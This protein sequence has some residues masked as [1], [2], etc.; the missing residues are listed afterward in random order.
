MNEIEQKF[1]D[2]YK[3][4]ADEIHFYLLP[5][6]VIGIYTVDF[7]MGDCVA[8]IDGH[9]Y[10]KTK[11]QRYADY[12]RERFLQKLGYTVVRFMGTE[13]FLDPMKCVNELYEIA[14]L[15]EDKEV[16]SFFKGVEVGKNEK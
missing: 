3:Q 4:A 6:Q 5:Q 14:R 8:E 15:V 2:A 13:V 11:E 9:E 7:I 10:H 1:Y 12:T 16:V